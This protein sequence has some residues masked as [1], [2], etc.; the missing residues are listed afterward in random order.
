MFMRE[1]LNY[2]PDDWQAEVATAL[3]NHKWVTVRSGQGVGKSALMSAILLWFL[4]THP[5]PRVVC[6]A[7]TGQQLRDVLWSEVA[8]WM[9]NSP[10]LTELLKWTK[11]YIYLKGAEKRW[12]AVQRVAT[13]PENMQGFHEDNMLFLVD[14]ASGIKDD[15]M[16]A[17]LGTLT[18]PNNRLI[19]CGNP[20]RPN[21]IFFDSHHGKRGDFKAFRVNSEDSTRT[22]KENI[23]ALAKAYGRESNV[24]RVRVLGE[25][26]VQED[27]VFI[28]LP[29]VE[30]SVKFTEKKD[31]TRELDPGD[32]H[33]GCDVARYGDDKTVIGFKIMERVE[34]YKKINGQD[35]MRTAADIVYLGEILRER[36]DFQYKI[37]IKVDDGGLGGGVTDRI[38]QIKASDPVYYHWMEII[39]VNFGAP[40]KHPRYQDSTTYMMSVVKSLLAPHDED[41]NA[42]D[43]E[44]ILPDDNDLIA[45][46]T[47]RK[48]SLNERGKIVIES[49]NAVKSRGLPSPDEADCVLLL[50]LPVKMKPEKKKQNKR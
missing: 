30:A 31:D 40:I 13:R 50:C 2:E 5:Y 36:H 12:F 19:L 46:L 11:T 6:T 21:G 9:S 20:T 16:E 42:K 41:G 26:P 4:M 48:Y 45:Q 38:R 14:E 32:I 44:I 18:G 23:E 49:K 1:V 35:L 47:T 37:P 22:S 28:P 15:I 34:F 8:K 25:F 33:I 39:P 3:T 24:Y 17:I 7:P 10:V 27:D 29:L 43:V